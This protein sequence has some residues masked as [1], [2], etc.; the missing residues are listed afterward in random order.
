VNEHGQQGHDHAAS[1]RD[2]FIDMK[3]VERVD[4]LLILFRTWI[5][6][7]SRGPF[8]AGFA[9][10]MLAWSRRDVG[11]PATMAMFEESEAG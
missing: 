4:S 8:V 11:L 10:G 5:T 3:P 9:D 7:I 1:R 6:R 2:T